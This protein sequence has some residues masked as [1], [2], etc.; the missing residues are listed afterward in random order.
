MTAARQADADADADDERG[1]ATPVLRE[2]KEGEHDEY[3][4]LTQ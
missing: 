3:E 1:Q 2:T 4:F